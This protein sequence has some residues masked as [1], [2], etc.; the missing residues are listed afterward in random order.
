L[1]KKYL[2]KF[3]KFYVVKLVN[4][5][6]YLVPNENSFMLFWPCILNYAKYFYSNQCKFHSKHNRYSIIWQWNVWEHLSDT[7]LEWTKCLSVLI[8]GISVQ[9]WHFLKI[10]EINKHICHFGMDLVIWPLV[11]LGK[12]MDCKTTIWQELKVKWSRTFVFNSYPLGQQNKTSPSLI[13]GIYG[14]KQ[15]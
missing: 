14:G 2:A 10:S 13:K 7:I 4:S 1:E 5:E 12:G 3:G 8:S 11:T 15:H 9:Y 6:K